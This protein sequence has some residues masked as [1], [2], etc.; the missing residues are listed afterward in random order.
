M[1]IR[2]CASKEGKLKNKLEERE[3][4]LE[5]NNKKNFP[6]AQSLFSFY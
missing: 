2:E 6:V 1:G 5:Q 4:V 3:F